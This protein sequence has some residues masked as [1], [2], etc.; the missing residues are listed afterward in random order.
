MAK[1]EIKKMFVVNASDIEKAINYHESKGDSSHKALANYLHGYEFYSYVIET[2]RLR[3]RP[4]D[5]F[6]KILSVVTD[7]LYEEKPVI[8]V[9]Y[10]DGITHASILIQ[11]TNNGL[12]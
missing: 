4:W 12:Q 10:I 2:F 3:V 6:R 8:M 5:G 9:R 11:P 1:K 7:S